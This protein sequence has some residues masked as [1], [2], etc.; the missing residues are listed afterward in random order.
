[1]ATGFP[2]IGRF[3]VA[4]GFAGASFHG[5]LLLATFHGIPARV[6][7]RRRGVAPDFSAGLPRAPRI[8]S[9]L[10]PIMAWFDTRRLREAA[11]RHGQQT[12]CG[13]RQPH[14]AH[15]K[16]DRPIHAFLLAKTLS[17]SLR[18]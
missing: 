7:A 18:L 4:R 14:E 13:E 3:D 2:S 16:V 1:L 17:P 5:P 6:A 8:L 11:R 9:I 15:S 12:G 10:T